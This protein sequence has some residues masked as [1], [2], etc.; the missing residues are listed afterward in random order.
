MQSQQAD[1]KAEREGA[2]WSGE[3][4]CEEETTVILQSAPDPHAAVWLAFEIVKNE[5]T[6]ELKTASKDLVVEDLPSNFVHGLEWFPAS[7]PPPPKKSKKKKF[8]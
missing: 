2:S 6:A 1:T 3:E 7:Q 4:L 8:N 5:Y